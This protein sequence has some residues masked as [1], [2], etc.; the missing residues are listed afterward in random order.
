MLAFEAAL[1]TA[2]KIPTFK[3]G[4]SILEAMKGGMSH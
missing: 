2:I 1:V 4:L 3:E